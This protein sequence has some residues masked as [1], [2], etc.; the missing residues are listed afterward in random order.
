MYVG[1][2]ENSHIARFRQTVDHHV[3]YMTLNYFQQA[4]DSSV[5]L[6]PARYQLYFTAATGSFKG[7]YCH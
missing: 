7:S 6:R 5:Y 4:N 3:L 2:H 1:W